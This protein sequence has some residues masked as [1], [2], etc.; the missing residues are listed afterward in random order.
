MAEIHTISSRS[1]LSASPSCNRDESPSRAPRPIRTTF[2]SGAAGRSPSY[3]KPSPYERRTQIHTGE[4]LHTVRAGIGGPAKRRESMSGIG[5]NL[6]SHNPA[7]LGRSVSRSATMKDKGPAR[8]AGSLRRRSRRSTISQRACFNEP[9]SPSAQVGNVM[10][11]RIE[12]RGSSSTSSP[13][14]VD[15]GSATAGLSIFPTNTE[16]SFGNRQPACHRTRS[17][18]GYSTSQ[19]P[20][21]YNQPI[22]PVR[23]RTSRS[24]AVTPLSIS[25]EQAEEILAPFSDQ[26]PEARSLDSDT[27]ERNGFENA[28]PP[29][30]VNMT[31]GSPETGNIVDVLGSS[32]QP[33]VVYSSVRKPSHIG[34]AVEGKK[35]MQV[36][37]GIGGKQG[38][39]WMADRPS[40]LGAPAPRNMHPESGLTKL[41]RRIGIGKK[42]KNNS[43]NQ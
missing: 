21:S 26:R 2:S 32:S 31:I 27:L 24:S 6:R 4:K 18:F 8:P 9:E 38:K 34:G 19:L 23:L 7:G 29:L 10:I 39:D 17:S 36:K 41:L 13:V 16:F 22:S 35:V 20:Q 25:S 11:P 33:S 28:S 1:S 37:A 3:G 15:A 12:R 30:N 40:S 5:N 42:Q 14:V 43:E